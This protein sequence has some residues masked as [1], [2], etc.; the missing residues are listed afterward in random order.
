MADTYA[1][2]GLTVLAVNL[3]SDSAHA[4]AFLREF[5]PT[6]EIRFDPAGE[7]PDAFH[8]KGMPTGILI[9]RHGITRYSHVGFLPADAPRYESELRELLHER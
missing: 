5:Q 4:A 6:F 7:L 8:V 2:Q 1:A 9:D 3:D